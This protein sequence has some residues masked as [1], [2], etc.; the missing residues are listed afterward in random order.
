MFEVVTSYAPIAIAFFLGTL[1][2]RLYESVLTV[3][4]HIPDQFLNYVNS[5]L[6]PRFGD[7]GGK[8]VLVV[9][10]AA[11]MIIKQAGKMLIFLGKHVL[12]LLLT[13]AENIYDMI[14]YSEILDILIPLV[15]MGF[16]AVSTA[17]QTVWN[18]L[19]L[20]FSWT[21]SAMKTEFVRFAF[22]LILLYL[23]LHLLIW[24]IKRML[25]KV[26]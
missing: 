26:V 15:K 22:H 24:G 25:K 20:F 10:Q 1:I 16:T 12:P 19:V 9:S 11:V 14:L 5:S 8:I 21:T 17:V 23:S 18:E 2:P 4:F 3:F 13:I 6:V 7:N